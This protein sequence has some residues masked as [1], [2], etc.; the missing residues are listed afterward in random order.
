M[1]P[2]AEIDVQANLKWSLNIAASHSMMFTESPTES[3]PRP[4][5]LVA[6]PTSLMYLNFYDIIITYSY[7]LYYGR[8]DRDVSFELVG[9]QVGS[10]LLNSLSQGGLLF[11]SKPGVSIIVVLKR[12]YSNI[13]P[14]SVPN[15]QAC[16]NL[17]GFLSRRKLNTNTPKI[18]VRGD[19]MGDWEVIEEGL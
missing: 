10:R 14:L 1:L 2:L 12:R 9:R 19:E 5:R 6:P 18:R 8:S 4:T 3:Y 7:L 16:K 11:V 17:C 13:Y 15:S